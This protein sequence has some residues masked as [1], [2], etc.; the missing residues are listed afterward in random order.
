MIQMANDLLVASNNQSKAKESKS[1]D[2]QSSDKEFA[3]FLMMENDSLAAKSDLSENATPRPTDAPFEKG[4]YNE[5]VVPSAEDVSQKEKTILNKSED[6]F[7]VN[8]QSLIDVIDKNEGESGEVMTSDENDDLKPVEVGLYA[9]NHRLITDVTLPEISGKSMPITEINPE[10][11]S[12]YPEDGDELD[13]ADK[14]LSD[15]EKNVNSHNKLNMDKSAFDSKMDEA[16]KN[17]NLAMDL[18]TEIKDGIKDHK[19]LKAANESNAAD[20]VSDEKVA[21]L[22]AN[23]AQIKTEMKETGE[24]VGKSGFDIDKGEALKSSNVDNL[25]NHDEKQS[26]NKG[27]DS[28]HKAAHKETAVPASDL[29]IDL[30][31][32]IT[33]NRH[34]F[35]NFMHKVLEERSMISDSSPK[36]QPQQ[37]D[38]VNRGPSAFSE[39]LKNV[40]RFIHT[41]GLTKAT[42]IIDPPALGRVNIEIISTDNG[43]ETILKV[44]NEQVKMLVEDHINQLKQNLEQ[45]GVKLAE[46]TVDIQQDKGNS[47]DQASNNKSRK[48][49]LGAA[50]EEESE[51]E[52]IEAFRVDLRK[53]LLH[54]IA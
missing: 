38:L 25:T 8:F 37:M 5:K 36:L 34:E 4:A 52:R 46:V 44:S 39:G 32:D 1:R 21:E 10:Q 50:E 18:K 47:R 42:L 20:E 41:G 9:L 12:F 54:W 22:P 48:T 51:A 31:K 28:D 23:K 26:N 49:R 2:S 13:N 19:D 27:Y 6:F 53:G 29:E 15:N 30:D 14:L 16:L 24:Q 7:I 33:T 43:I 45:I 3:S 11:R 17:Q 35:Q 40:V